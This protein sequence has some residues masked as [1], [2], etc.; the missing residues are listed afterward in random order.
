[1]TKMSFSISDYQLEL[2][3]IL[4]L[5]IQNCVYGQVS[6]MVQTSLQLLVARSNK[7]KETY[8]VSITG[9]VVSFKC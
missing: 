7:R 9:L 5:H 6:E 1:M 4:Q 3:F 8:A 2:R